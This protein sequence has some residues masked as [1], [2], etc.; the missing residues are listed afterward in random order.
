MSQTEKEKREAQF[1]GDRNYRYTLRIRW[2]EGDL[3]QFIGL[4]PSTADELQDDPTIRRCKRFAKDFGAG[5]MVMTNLF[6]WRSTDPSALTKVQNPIGE[7]GQFITVGGNEF[8]NRN[9]FH[10]FTTALQCQTRIACWGTHGKILY[11]GAKVK[12]WLTGLSCLSITKNGCPQ[13]PLYLKSDLTPIPF[14]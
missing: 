6:A 5:G 9:D 12:Q 2:A 4:N 3:V 10:L 11:R 1:S 7:E 8:L 13:H 14:S